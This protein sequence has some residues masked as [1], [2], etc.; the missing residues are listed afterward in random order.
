MEVSVGGVLVRPG[1]AIVGDDDGVVVVPAACA[2]EVAGI[3]EVRET[4]EEVI[5]A[6]L[7]ENPQPPGIYYPFSTPVSKESPLGK[8]LVDKGHA[9]LVEGA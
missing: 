2:D 7:T 3:A 6:E 8:L 4:I 9:G 1:D 5:K